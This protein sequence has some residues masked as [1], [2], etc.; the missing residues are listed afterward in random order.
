MLYIHFIYIVNE[1][2]LF[3]LVRIISI[4]TIRYIMDCRNIVVVLWV[5][6]Y[7]LTA[8]EKGSDN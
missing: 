8:V 2:V 6:S 1:R 4:Q 3:F 7:E 5:I